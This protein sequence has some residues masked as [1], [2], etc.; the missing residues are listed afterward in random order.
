MAREAEGVVSTVVP[1]LKV[2]GSRAFF[3]SDTHY[4]HANICRATSKWPPDETRWFESLE[5]MNAALVDGINRT[6]P[7][8]AVLFH[9]GDWSF[10]G[11]DKIGEFRN[12]LAVREIHLILGNHDHHLT[13]GRELHHF[14][15]VSPYREIMVDGQEIVLFHYGM[16]VWNASHKG[17]WLLYGHSHGSL[18]PHGRSMDVGVDT[19]VYQPYSFND[20][21]RILAHREMP[22]VDHHGLRVEV[23]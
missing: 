15:S 12:R 4:A 22:I 1:L 7:Y 16:R 2:D 14:T 18:P 17:S 3:T 21:R 20:V 23:T 6:V 9:L 13:K 11:Q 5:A 10:A 19:N 8:D